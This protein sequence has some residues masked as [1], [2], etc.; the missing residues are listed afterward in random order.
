MHMHVKRVQFSIHSHSVLLRRCMPPITPHLYVFVCYHMHTNTGVC[1]YFFAADGATVVGH[2]VC[3]YC[4]VSPQ[5]IPLPDI[6]TGITERA[7][8]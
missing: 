8:L 7:V 4:R 3:Y 5:L 2:V 6:N 1:R